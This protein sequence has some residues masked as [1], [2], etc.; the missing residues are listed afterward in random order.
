MSPFCFSASPALAPESAAVP[1]AAATRGRLKRCA[2]GS[3]TGRGSV[4]SGMSSSGST[5]T[6][7]RR[8]VD[9]SSDS[10]EVSTTNRV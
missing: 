6:G 4:V 9:K 1:S 10:P 5:G 7:S 2:G 8:P 3:T